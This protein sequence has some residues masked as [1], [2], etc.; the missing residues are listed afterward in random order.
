MPIPVEKK[1]FFVGCLF[2]ELGSSFGMGSFVDQGSEFEFGRF[3]Y[4]LFEYENFEDGCF[5]AVHF[6]DGHFDSSELDGKK[7]SFADKTDAFADSDRFWF[8]N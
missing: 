3:G 1:I 6:E 7:G 8:Q 2:E 4:G 5:E